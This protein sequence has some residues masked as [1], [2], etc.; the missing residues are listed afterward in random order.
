MI[1]NRSKD[2]CIECRKE[3]EYH[4]MKKDIIRTIKKK[5][6]VFQITVAVCMECGM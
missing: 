4:L 1:E 6:Y 5:E 2:F 3:T